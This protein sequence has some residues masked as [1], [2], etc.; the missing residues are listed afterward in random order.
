MKVRKPFSLMQKDE[1]S[2]HWWCPRLVFQATTNRW[3]PHQQWGLIRWAHRAVVTVTRCP[4]PTWWAAVAVVLVAPRWH[5][6][7]STTPSILTR[8]KVTNLPSRTS[9][10]IGHPTACTNY[11]SH[12][13]GSSSKYYIEQMLLL[14]I[15][16]TLA[17]YITDEKKLKYII[18]NSA[19]R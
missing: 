3:C 9:L 12:W 4:T 15:F 1:D 19:I 11:T 5:P 7:P 2:W 13:N 10:N 6:I 17:L 14:E 8:H 16:T 18:Q